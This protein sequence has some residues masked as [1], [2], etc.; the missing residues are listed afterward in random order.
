LKAAAA[1]NPHKLWVV[2]PCS[3]GRS[4][5]IEIFTSK[6]VANFNRQNYF[7]VAQEYVNRPFLWDD[8]YKFHFRVYVLVPRWSP[9]T[10]L[11]YNDGLIF[12]S[13]VKYDPEKPVKDRDIF[14]SVSE[15]VDPLPLEDLWAYLGPANATKVRSDLLQ[16][17]RELLGNSLEE[18][19]GSASTVD[20]DLRG[21]ECFDF[22]GADVLLTEELKPA[23]LE[24]N[25]SP[26]LWVDDI[27]TQHRP[28]MR[29]LKRPLVEDIVRWAAAR[30][31]CGQD[32][33]CKRE[34]TAYE[35]LH[36]FTRIL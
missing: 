22:F 32:S 21:Y 35:A 8:A 6:N 13:R 2:K 16:M 36:H 15:T 34:S 20:E 18:S 12:R 24:I 11:L 14:S 1:I 31:R 30:L 27:G 19:F 5:G 33:L 28:L 17:L 3:T 7:A 25:M 23:L 4:Q 10:A 29:Q 26:N 9:P